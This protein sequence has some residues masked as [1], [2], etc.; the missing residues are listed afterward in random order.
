MF[1]SVTVLGL[2]YIRINCA[3]ISSSKDQLCYTVD[4]NIFKDKINLEGQ[5]SLT[6]AIDYNDDRIFNFSVE[7]QRNA[8]KEIDGFD[9]IYQNFSD[10]IIVE[11]ISMILN[12][13][14]EG[15]FFIFHFF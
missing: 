6:L 8:Y 15:Y 5:L 12:M 7:N 13:Y 1:L 9:E 2:Q 10:S 4:P 14:D 11:T 3:C